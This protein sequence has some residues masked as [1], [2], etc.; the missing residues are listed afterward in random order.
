MSGKTQA[1]R[2]ALGIRYFTK[3]PPALISRLN[4]MLRGMDALY[5]RSS[6]DIVGNVTPDGTFARLRQAST[7]SRQLSIAV[8]F[9]PY[10]ASAGGELRVG[11]RVGRVNLQVPTL[12]GVPL[13]D[14]TP[15]YATISATTWF[16]L[17]VV[18]TFGLPDSYVVTIET[19]TSD[20]AP[21]VEGITST[22]FTS[23]LFLAK[24]TVSGAITNLEPGVFA[25][26]GVESYGNVNNW[27]ALA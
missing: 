17:Q 6:G 14:A 21:T 3:G 10:D 23:C 7:S 16:W 19:S 4:E 18:A 22:G 2:N 1:G 9:A 15:P 20:T 5:L 24:A 8:P 27:W 26:L 12:D 25:N 11:F 13:D